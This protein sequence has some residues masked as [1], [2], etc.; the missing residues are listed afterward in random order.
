M[1]TAAP[2]RSSRFAAG[3]LR[4]QTGHRRSSLAM[5]LVQ[6]SQEKRKR[7]Q[8]RSENDRQTDQSEADP[9]QAGD[10]R[11][12][13]RD[14]A[15]DL[16]GLAVDQQS[17]RFG[18]LRQRTAHTQTGKRARSMASSV[19]SV[20]VWSWRCESPGMKAPQPMLITVLRDSS[21]ASSSERDGR[22][23]APRR[24]TPKSRPVRSAA[25]PRGRRARR[26]RAR[27]FGIPSDAVTNRSSTYHRWGPTSERYSVLVT[28]RV[29]FLPGVVFRHRVVFAD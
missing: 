26:P 8:K 23:S 14:S 18:S 1:S 9:D 3:Q 29:L 21:R 2:C 19:R 20:E 12:R 7:S 22:G 10:L 4:L 11:P 13:D 15:G 25:G 17:G 5:A 28:C 16:P 6:R 27:R 24:S